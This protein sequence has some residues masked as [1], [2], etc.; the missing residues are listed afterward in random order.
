VAN[1]I[2]RLE[3]T[4]LDPR[5]AAAL[6]PRV[7]RLGYLGEFFKCAGHQPDALLAFM[8]FT[9]ALKKALPDRLTELVAL[10]VAALARNDYERHQ[11]ERLSDKLGFGRDWIRAVL[12]LAPD[13]AGALSDAE[14]AVQRLAI[15]ALKDHGHD[16]APELAQAIAAV[17]HEQAIAVLM[18]IGRYTTH[19]L[20][21]NA[22]D[23][24]PPVASIFADERG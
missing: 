8:E 22:I 3:M 15:A 21:V 11:H 4:D 10:T 1:A 7:A 20:I 2:P 16:A 19:A 9:E 13:K 14:R 18:L 23:L 5:I 17:G 12:A 24:A 6:A